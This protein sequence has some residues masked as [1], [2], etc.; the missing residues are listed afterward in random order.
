MIIFKNKKYYTLKEYAN[1][2]G[3]SYATARTHII[4]KYGDMLTRIAKRL[5]IPGDLFEKIT[6]D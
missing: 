6:K 4:E 1:E 3:L 2:T 5:Y